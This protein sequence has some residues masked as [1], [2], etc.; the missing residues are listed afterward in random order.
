LDAGAPKRFPADAEK[1][2]ARPQAKLFNSIERQA[3]ANARQIAATHIR[4]QNFRQ[5]GFARARSVTMEVDALPNRVFNFA[6]W[7]LASA[8]P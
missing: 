2:F 3:V 6:G 5:R 4:Q 8:R 1:L 7:T